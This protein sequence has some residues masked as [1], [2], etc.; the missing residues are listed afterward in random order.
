VLFEHG[1]HGCVSEGV[2][3]DALADGYLENLAGQFGDAV[4]VSD[5]FCE[6]WT[7]I[8]LIY[9]TPFYCYASRFGHL[10]VLV[11]H[12]EYREEGGAFT[13]R[14]LRMLAHGKP[15]SPERIIS[16][17]ASDLALVDF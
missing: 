9:H 13:P 16:E 12:R 15:R 10:L 6:K 4:E 14:L 5:E 11:L 17:P 1:A 3:A 7:A 8:P 2:T